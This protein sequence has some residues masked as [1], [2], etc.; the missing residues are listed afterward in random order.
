MAV[1]GRRV[2]QQRSGQPAHGGVAHRRAEKCGRHHLL[3]RPSISIPEH[4]RG[5]TLA[6]IDLSGHV[7]KGYAGMSDVRLRVTDQASGQRTASR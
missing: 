7:P 4:L 2:L 1:G 3:G 5:A 6:D